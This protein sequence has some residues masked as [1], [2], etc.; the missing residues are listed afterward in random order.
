MFDYHIHTS[1][2]GDCEMEIEIAL[3]SAIKKGL[4]NIAITDHM[5]YESHDYVCNMIL[6]TDSYTPKV[7]EIINRYNGIIDIS[8][9]V[10]L[11]M[12][13][14]I[15]KWCDEYVRKY[16]F[17]FVIGSIHS[18][19]C[20]DIYLDFTKGKS[21]LDC[22]KG[23]LNDLYKCVTEFQQFSVIGHFDVIRR[24]VEGPDKSFLISEYPDF[25][26]EIFKKII[27]KGKGIE[28]NTSGLRYNLGS[29]HPQTDFLIRYKELGGEVI[30]V[31]SDAHRPESVGQYIPEALDLLKD[32]GFRYVCR[33]K[34]ME[35]EFIKI[36]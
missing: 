8:M 29:F 28:V 34:S 30:T 4:K 10:E 16:K 11:G 32:L 9:G 33:F 6:D 22:I 18:V 25:I 19:E 15:V 23:Y 7:K 36:P 14:Q 27:H 26:D 12:Q 3:E 24:Y 31:G 1:F 20:K 13:P 5:D 35:P 2:S 21:R 17:D